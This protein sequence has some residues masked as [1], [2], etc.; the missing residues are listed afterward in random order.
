MYHKHVD[1]GFGSN[2]LHYGHGLVFGN[3]TPPN[4]AMALRLAGD[5]LDAYDALTD[6]VTLAESGVERVRNAVREKCPMYVYNALSTER[7]SIEIGQAAIR[8]E[9]NNEG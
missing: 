1:W 7:W 5:Y 3:V 9:R 4:G 2:A 8:K 6:K